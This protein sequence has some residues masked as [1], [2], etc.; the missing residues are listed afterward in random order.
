MERQW[1]FGVLAVWAVLVATKAVFALREGATYTFSI[2]DGGMIRAGKSLSRRG[3]VAK[4]ITLT[5]LVA[6]SVAMIAGASPYELYFRV[7]LAA[8]IGSL[9]LDFAFAQK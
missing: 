2:W 6:C 8:A 1:I 7:A 4:L 9:V 5:V 3:V